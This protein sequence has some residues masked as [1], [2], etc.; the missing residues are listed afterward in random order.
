MFNQI[1]ILIPS[2]NPDEKLLKTIDGL[3][4]VGFKNF[5]I[6]N[7]PVAFA[8]GFVILGDILRKIK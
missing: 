2:L 1:C 3:K 5:I 8:A 6:Q 4:A 7:F